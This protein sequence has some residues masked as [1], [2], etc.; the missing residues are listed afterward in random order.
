MS[1]TITVSDAIDNLAHRISWISSDSKIPSK[2]TGLTKKYSELLPYCHNESALP[3]FEYLPV[4]EVLG[5]NIANIGRDTYDVLLEALQ[6]LIDLGL[7]VCKGNSG[8]TF[9][10][11]APDLT[12]SRHLRVTL[13]PHFLRVWKEIGKCF[14]VPLSLISGYST[15]THGI[16]VYF[17]AFTAKSLVE[18]YRTQDYR[19][20]KSNY[21]YEIENPEELK[22]IWKKGI[23]DFRLRIPVK[24]TTVN[25]V[26]GYKIECNPK[27]FTPNLKQLRMWEALDWLSIDDISDSTPKLFIY[28]TEGTTQ[29]SDYE[30]YKEIQN[31]FTR[32]IKASCYVQDNESVILIGIKDWLDYTM[33]FFEGLDNLINEFL[34]IWE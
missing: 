18:A 26:L 3:G 29:I 17:P 12:A 27:I 20:L 33:S 2:L 9:L 23:G 6:D 24:K 28:R 14:P 22:L 21:G 10:D 30:I 7:V 25:G 1:N 13:N 34:Q 5:H 8:Y 15:V 11:G 19:C 4:H 16:R 31:S 32:R